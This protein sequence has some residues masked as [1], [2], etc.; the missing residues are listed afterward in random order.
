MLVLNLD[1]DIPC[2]LLVSW[3]RHGHLALPA[4]PDVAHPRGVWGTLWN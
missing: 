1:I 4:F 3:K 2:I